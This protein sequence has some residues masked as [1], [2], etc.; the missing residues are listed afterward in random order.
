VFRYEDIALAKFTLF[1]FFCLHWSA[2]IFSWLDENTCGH[3]PED[4]IFVDAELDGSSIGEERK[5]CGCGCGCRAVQCS[6]VL[7]IWFVFRASILRSLLLGNGH[8]DYYWLR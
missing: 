4:S 3:S 6:A 8:H 5:G 1:V 7:T 2:C